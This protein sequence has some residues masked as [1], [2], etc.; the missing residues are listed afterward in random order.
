MRAER[1]PGIMITQPRQQSAEFAALLQAQ[2]ARVFVFAMIEVSPLDDYGLVD[3]CLNSGRAYDWLIL[4]SVNGVNLLRLRA[5]HLGLELQQ[6]FKGARIAAVGPKTAQALEG[7]GLKVDLIPQT[8]VSESLAESLIAQGIQGRRI[9]ALRSELAR[10]NLIKL[11]RQAGAEVD[12]LAIYQIKAPSEPERQAVRQAVS[13]GLIEI[14]TFTSAS[15]VEHF[16]QI[17]ARQ[18]E[19]L[20]GLKFASIGPVTSEACRRHFGRV[21]FE[22]SPH[23]LQG[24]ADV[25]CLGV[26][27]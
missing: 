7:L 8:Y 20:E 25:L 19:L 17:F 9:L 1:Q 2:G 21:E 3:Q 23:T 10:E 27:A 26:P 6:R 14:V 11:L 12:A 22:A 18:P 24:L 15:A 5:E 4:T 13:Q 16:A